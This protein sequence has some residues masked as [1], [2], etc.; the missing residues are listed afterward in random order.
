MIFIW[1]P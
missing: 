1:A